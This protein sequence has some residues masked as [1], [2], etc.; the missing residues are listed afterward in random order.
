MVPRNT[1]IGMIW[2][3]RLSSLNAHSHT[4][5]DTSSLEKTVQDRILEVQ[6]FVC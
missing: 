4:D 5:H 3:V 2:Y 6:K 1:Q